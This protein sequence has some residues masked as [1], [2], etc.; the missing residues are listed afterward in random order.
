M[1]FAARSLADRRGYAFITVLTLALGIGASTI[2][3]SVV[4]KVVV[5]PLP[6][7]DADHIVYVFSSDLIR[8]PS[9][10]LPTTSADFL[11]WRE[12][13]TSFRHMV[14]GRSRGL[15]LAGPTHMER[16][17]VTEMS[18]GGFEMLGVSP[19]L[20]S[21][22]DSRS[23]DTDVVLAH[24]TW[25][26]L[27]A[28]DA[29][30]LGR[31]IR[32]G[33][34]R[35]TVVGVMPQGFRHPF[36]ASASMWRRLRLGAGAPTERSTRSL[37]V[38]ATLKTDVGEQ[39]ASDEMEA[40]AAALAAEFPRSNENWGVNLLGLKDIYLEDGRG[41]YVILAAAGTLVLLISCANVAGLVLARGAARQTELAIR[42]ALG[43]GRSRLVR[44]FLAEGCMIAAAS[45]ALAIGIAI[46]GMAAIL[47]LAPAWPPVL[48]ETTL[49]ARSFAFA[50]GA[51]T[52]SLVL[53]SV[54]PALGMSQPRP[55]HAL[56]GA[57][58]VAGG[59]FR[60]LRLRR[61]LVVAQVSLAI[62]LMVGTG[63]L[64]R[65]VFNIVNANSG[66]DF[67]GVVSARVTMNVEDRGADVYFDDLL[68]R[69]AALPGVTSAALVDSAPMDGYG[70][71]VRVYVD[72]R[73][74]QAARAL[75]A[76]YRRV[77]PSY[78]D[79]LS[80]ERT[81]GR[82]LTAADGAGEAVAVIN[83]DFARRFLAGRDPVGL[84]V[85]VAPSMGLESTDRLREWRIV[86]VVKTVQEWGPTSFEIPMIY[87][88]HAADPAASMSLL[89]RTGAR[90]ET[91]VAPLR[92]I[93][94]DVGDSPVDRVR[95]LASYF[96]ET[97]ETQ[98][99][100]LALLAAF[101]GL[102][103]VLALVGLYGVIAYHVVQRHREIGVR[104]ALGAESRDIV[105]L[106][107]RQ[108]TRLASLAVVLG[109][110]GAIPLARALS[111][112]SMGRLLVDV[113]WLDPV[114]FGSVPLLI[115]CIAV[116][117]S[118]IPSRRAARV[119]PR[120]VLRSEP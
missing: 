75:G 91:L 12:R 72:G 33:G 68:E 89:L 66:F 29:E 87:V 27:F 62:V 86:G 55:G 67:R 16:V 94:R 109:I 63:L 54:L 96:E 34:E 106:F 74:M 24:G 15:V 47:P 1:R 36:S 48:R 5:E 23:A 113:H 111:T 98:R 7:A 17:A 9:S 19:I 97:Y 118:W 6:Y 25:Q 95:T 51:S 60:S 32:L 103:V 10:R 45:M 61:V 41:M 73:R 50:L 90:A 56:G 30:V 99:F 44:L 88:P 38:L 101:A 102:A 115:L 80:I 110:G 2:V 26:R 40:I 76:D 83:E 43:A 31:V 78:F 120:D 105:R 28:A 42:V 108:G 21:S 65:S 92:G 77:S 35:H 46:W 85:S 119:D 114:A 4:D 58:H 81:A 57:A 84:T 3:F 112:L 39:Q 52:V 59:S 116:L 49:T 53:F 104:V 14:A 64:I 37:T 20:G 18:D 93:I 100:L 13:S 11:D 69:A 70:D 117:A 71:W 22:L 82:L 79:T 107:L 8:G